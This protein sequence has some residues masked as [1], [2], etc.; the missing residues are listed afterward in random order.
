MQTPTF[1]VLPFPATNAALPETVER[2]LQQL[3]GPLRDTNNDTY[4]LA[5]PLERSRYSACPSCGIKFHIFRRK[6]NC[7]NCGQVVCSDC[8]ETKWYLPK[9][10]LKSAAG[11]CKM[12]DRSLH[13]SIKSKEDLGKVPVR[14]LRAYL[15]LYGLYNPSRML[16]K[17]DLVAAVYN[18][19]PMPQIHEEKY[20]QS[21]PQPSES[22]YTNHAQSNQSTQNH[23]NRN[24][25][26]SQDNNAFDS[27][28]GP[29]DSIFS[30]IGNEMGRAFEN[31]G[32]QVGSGVERGASI[33]DEHVSSVLDPA[34]QSH[35]TQRHTR[36]SAAAGSSGN[37]PSYNSQTYSSPSSHSQRQTHPRTQRSFYNEPRPQSSQRPSPNP[38]RPASRPA[39]AAART[40][41][42]TT[43]GP[44]ATTQNTV[45]DVR[46]LVKDGTDVNKLGIK[47]LKGI[48]GKHHVDYSNIVEKNE[49]VERV[50]RL[51]RN[52][53]LEMER[54]TATVA[55][56]SGDDNGDSTDGNDKDV[57]KICWDASINC[58]FLNC[59]HMCTCLECGNKIVES[60]R[61]ECPICR[62]HIAKVVHVFRV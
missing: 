34:L 47:M 16:E 5:K 44:S 56:A 45:P 22:N 50:E 48:L 18:N 41:E 42:G 7:A 11:C 59:G 6:C 37:R 24:G 9:Y 4:R 57:C 27:S 54:E 19:S 35:R 49:L 15:Q 12:C 38:N 30:N 8:V 21:L 17:S 2:A 32:Q 28:S 23:Q 31:I 26:N 25:S 43:G 60:D 62:G 55:S 29:W 40:T 46:S 14:E 33:L 39:A 1:N 10:G 3:S 13:M 36:G 53:K 51:V 20:R 52:T 61:R 58:V